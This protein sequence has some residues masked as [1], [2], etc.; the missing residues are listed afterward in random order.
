[1]QKF[2]SWIA[3]LTN[4]EII[5]FS[6]LVCGFMLFIPLS[7]TFFKL[8]KKLVFMK[9]MT[10]K[11]FSYQFYPIELI[12][13]KDGKSIKEF[14]E[15]PEFVIEG[16]KVLLYWEVEGALSIGLYPRYG[17]VKGNFSE[18]IVNRNFHEFQLISKGLFSKETIS[19][20]IPL[21]K[22]KTLET[23]MISDSK[24]FSE[25]PFIESYS[26]TEGDH[27]NKKFSQDLNFC[28]IFNK[29]VVSNRSFVRLSNRFTKDL[30]YIVNGN[31]LSE[32]LILNKQISEN[33]I[34]KKYTFSTNKYNQVNKL[35]NN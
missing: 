21:D 24:I 22:I 1:M 17:K 5:G 25:V 4:T 12:T 9:R 27:L 11:S 33:K 6:I 10:V 7:E 34:L 26:F 15:T 2:F 3:G 35:K 18:V 13:E 16:S 20:S 14:I 30:T 32:K 8:I 28:S 19:I 23:K 31:V 29:N